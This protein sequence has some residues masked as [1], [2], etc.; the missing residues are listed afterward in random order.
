MKSNRIII[1]ILSLALSL[2]A[3]SL[4]RAQGPDDASPP[5][6]HGPPNMTAMMTHVLNLTDAQKTQI[7]PLVDAAQPQLKAIHEQARTAADAV[8][9]QLHTQIRPLLTPEQQKK[10]DA[11]DTLRDSGMHGPGPE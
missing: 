7:Q 3:G 8:I 5:H 11:M 2:T 4:A 10:L 6:R 9:K 1:S